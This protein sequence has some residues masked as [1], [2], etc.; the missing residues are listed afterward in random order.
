MRIAIVGQ[1][2]IGSS[3]ALA[4]LEK[5]PGYSVTLFGDKPFEKTCSF[6]PAGL[7]RLDRYDDRELAK[8]TF[9]RFSYLDK[10]FNGNDTGIKLL[11]GHIQSDNHDLLK[12]QEKNYADIV[13]NF[14]WL[15]QREKDS[16]FPN[17]SR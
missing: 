3:T 16:L 15:D 7:F 17:P 8:L 12:T 14:R 5:Y 2:V 10:N 6:G 11:S 4:I 1:G 13:Y 9:E